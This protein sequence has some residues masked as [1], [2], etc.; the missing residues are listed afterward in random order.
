[1]AVGVEARGAFT[2]IFTTACHIHF[3]PGE[4]KLPAYDLNALALHV[5]GKKLPAPS[6]PAP[7]APAPAPA[8]A[9]APASQQLPLTVDA[10]RASC[11]LAAAVALL[12]LCDEMGC[13]QGAVN[14]ADRSGFA[15]NLL[16]KS[17]LAG[18]ALCMLQRSAQACGKLL[19]F[20]ALSAA[21]ATSSSSLPPLVHHLPSACICSADALG[22]NRVLFQISNAVLTRCSGMHSDLCL[23]F[24][25]SDSLPL[26]VISNN[27]S[28]ETCPSSSS[29][30]SSSSPLGLLPSLVQH[31]MTN[32]PRPRAHVTLACAI[33]LLP[34]SLLPH[35]PTAAALESACAS[36][37]ASAAAALV[38]GFT[39]AEDA[40][41]AA[42]CS[43]PLSSTLGNRDAMRA[44]AA[45]AAGMR[46]RVRLLRA[47]MGEVILAVA[48]ASAGNALHVKTCG[49]LAGAAAGAA[50]A[51]AGAAVVRLDCMMAP[52]LIYSPNRS[53][54][55]P[56]PPPLSPPCPPPP[57]PLLTPPQTKLTHCASTS[58]AG[59]RVAA[60][61][62]PAA[63]ISSN[64]PSSGRKCRFVVTCFSRAT[65]SNL[66]LR[67]CCC[68][69]PSSSSSSSSSIAAAAAASPF[70]CNVRFQSLFV[71]DHRPSSRHHSHHWQ[72]SAGSR[73]RQVRSPAPHPHRRACAC[74][75]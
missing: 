56:P 60:P 16:M 38:A 8:H 69:C 12:Q 45:A 4:R 71:R 21:C 10:P 15:P 5:L 1:M 17:G 34:L 13:V 43:L 32:R 25:L 27:V 47:D 28:Y 26:A 68:C 52:L 50:A 63:V 54:R 33:S 20:N 2:C 48:N 65:S 73:R 24:S 51:A 30:S 36:H 9:P 35:A 66:L 19:P 39:R 23:R 37:V 64:T 70:R 3:Y 29:S 59:A 41:S 61:S 55:H 14:V 18:A 49:E 42:L 74:V 7:P 11:A 58:Y 57:P 53:A 40:A 46:M 31:L 6:P 62:C 22:L 75:R 72:H 67:C 44:Q